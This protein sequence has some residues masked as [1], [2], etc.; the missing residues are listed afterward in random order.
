MQKSS[1]G[2]LVITLATALGIVVTMGF[3]CFHVG[4]VVPEDH[5]INLAILLTSIAFGWL[6]GTFT[7]PDSPDEETRF[8]RYGT[9]IKA[10]VS[11]YLISKCD[12]LVTAI[13]D[14]D[15]L[16]KQLPLFRFL[17][18]L[19][20]LLVATMVTYILREYVLQSPGGFTAKT[21]KVT[22]ISPLP[23]T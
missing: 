17:L 6:L 18:C 3:L 22:T 10:F 1:F 7:S 4:T 13:L 16:F 9:A 14:P 21:S 2:T 23:P 20:G 11:G 5:I 12:K 15:S 19:S 8:S